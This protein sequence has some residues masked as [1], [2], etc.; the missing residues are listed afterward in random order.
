MTDTACCLE[1]LGEQTRR[2]MESIYFL[3]RERVACLFDIQSNLL[4]IHFKF[5]FW[6]CPLSSDALLRLSCN[7]WF[8]PQQLDSPKKKGTVFHLHHIF[9]FFEIFKMTLFLKRKILVLLKFDNDKLCQI[10][11]SPFLTFRHLL[12]NLDPEA[13]TELSF[14]LGIRG[15]KIQSPDILRWHRTHGCF[16]CWHYAS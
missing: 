16:S 13:E 5:A 12:C 8:K 1:L 10:N 9:S 15:K 14:G 2:Q 4:L 11:C 6:R 7:Y 3:G